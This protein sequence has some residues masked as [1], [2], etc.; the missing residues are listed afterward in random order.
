M[1]STRDRI[2]VKPGRARALKECA[3]NVTIEYS[4]R[5]NKA[6]AETGIVKILMP[7]AMFTAWKTYKRKRQLKDELHTL[8]RH[9]VYKH[10]IFRR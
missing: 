5:R 1:V 10:G 6:G 8:F 2:T 4:V 9:T 7:S 3:P